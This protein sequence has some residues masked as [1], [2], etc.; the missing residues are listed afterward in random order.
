MEGEREQ[1]CLL[2]K[3]DVRAELVKHAALAILSSRKEERGSTLNKTFSDCAICAQTRKRI[4]GFM[5]RINRR[6]RHYL[7]GT[8]TT[9]V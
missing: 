9:R 1:S 3:A 6:N 4:G 8:Y 5:S 2:R 7:G